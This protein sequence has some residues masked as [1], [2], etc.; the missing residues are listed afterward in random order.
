M[1][2]ASIPVS[3][4]NVGSASTNGIHT[5]S[6]ET[7]AAERNAEVV[8]GSVIE[9]DFL[10]VGCGPA[11][12]SLSCFLA[13]HGEFGIV[14]LSISIIALQWADTIQLQA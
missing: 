8:G 10:V 2:P 5:Q 4:S 7:P 12:A 3:A 9:T 14:I 11:G 6:I 13:S 1:S